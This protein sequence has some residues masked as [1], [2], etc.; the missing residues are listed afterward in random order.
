PTAGSIRATSW[1]ESDCPARR[2]PPQLCRRG[3]GKEARDETALRRGIARGRVDGRTQL[4][5]EGTN[6][7]GTG[8]AE[9]PADVAQLGTRLRHRN[10]DHGSGRADE[11]GTRRGPAAISA[12]A[13]RDD[14]ALR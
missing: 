8:R 11:R 4:R 3:S 13:R 5:G 12:A 10:H 2:S 9:G 7:D 6:G 14:D 1:T